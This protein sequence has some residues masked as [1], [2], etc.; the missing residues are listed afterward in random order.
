MR[1]HARVLALAGIAAS[2]VPLGA[3][4][5]VRIRTLKPA[6]H[7]E[8]ARPG[9]VIVQFRKGTDDRSVEHAIRDGGGLEARQAA[10]TPERYLVGLDPGIEVKDAVATFRRM[11]LVAAAEPNHIVRAQFV[12]ND[13]RYYLQWHFRLIG[14]ERMWDIQQGDP[15]VVVAVVDS[16]IAFED[17]G[18][19][20]K[21]P[22]WEG[23]VFVEGKNIFDGTAHANDDAGH[24]THV[25][26]T[27]A[28]ATNNQIGTAGLAFHTA[29]MPV[30]VLN[31]AGEG[32]EFGLAEGI[33]F[34]AANKNVKVINLSL[35]FDLGVTE[36]DLKA[37]KSSIDNA[38][39]AGITVVAA[40]GN[41]GAGEV[42]FPAAFANVISVGAVDARKELTSYS[43]YG[44]AL[45]V[46]APGGDCLRDDNHDGEADCVWQVTFDDVAAQHGD[47]SQ[48]FVIGYEGTSQATPHV[49]A[50]AALLVR[51][52]IT[53]P[54]GVRAAIESTALDLGAT[55]RDDRYGHGLIQPVAALSGLGFGQ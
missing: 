30:K 33:D 19:F 43:N 23:T 3:D 50:L 20:H 12:P 17:Y 27:I 47:Y 45:S 36:A 37:L 52:G 2:L 40:A 1:L 11:P 48:F 4:P 39:S 29:L 38:V 32:D 26:G 16:G 49:S 9:Q 34:A 51:Q 41:D 15:S 53:T 18:P 7:A 46:V 31:A 44:S 28:E 42:Q 6:S 35:G 8:S 24:G 5:L 13:R 22:D 54:A 55:G 10:L 21:S 14:A 25:A